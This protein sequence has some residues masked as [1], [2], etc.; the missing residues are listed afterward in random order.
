MTV[1]NAEERARRHG[2]RTSTAG[3]YRE[4]VVQAV[5]ENATL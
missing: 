4:A 1:N 2:G 3:A 5:T